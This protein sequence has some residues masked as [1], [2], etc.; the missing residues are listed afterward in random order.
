MI[1]RNILEGSWHPED[2]VTIADITAREEEGG[3]GDTVKPDQRK[4]LSCNP[5]LHPFGG[6]EG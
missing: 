5:P 1:A 6:V 3:R 2:Y 4:A